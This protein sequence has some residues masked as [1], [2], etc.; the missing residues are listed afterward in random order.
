MNDNCDKLC[1]SSPDLLAVTESSLQRR[2]QGKNREWKKHIFIDVVRGESEF[3]FSA[4]ERN[5]VA[6]SLYSS[7]WQVKK[8]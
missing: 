3:L 1:L 7:R 5:R 6:G 4:C 2:L 8:I